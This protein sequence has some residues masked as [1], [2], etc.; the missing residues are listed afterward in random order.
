M[1]STEIQVLH[2]YR[3]CCN[4]KTTTTT[5]TATTTTPSLSYVC[6]YIY[7]CASCPALFHREP[8]PIHHTGTHNNQSTAR[9]T[10][11]SEAVK[12]NH[13]PTTSTLHHFAHLPSYP[14][15][16]GLRREKTATGDIYCVAMCGT[17]KKKKT[18]PHSA[19]FEKEM[20]AIWWTTTHVDPPASPNYPA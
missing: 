4:A 5:T 15:T 20:H 2:G 1:H 6:A 12:I 10:R 11:Q 19:L 18:R 13:Q 9:T 7:W 14:P 3:N 8:T 17:E 16:D